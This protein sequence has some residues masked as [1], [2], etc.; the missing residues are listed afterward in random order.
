MAQSIASLENL[1]AL[2]LLSSHHKVEAMIPLA[3]IK[4]LSHLSVENDDF[5]DNNIISSVVLNSKS[6]LRS[7]VVKTNYYATSFLQGWEKVYADDSLGKEKHSLAVLKAFTLCG[8]T[9]DTTFIKSL[10]KAIDFMGLL[11]LTLGRFGVGERLFFQLLASLATSSQTSA[12]SIGLRNLCLDML[13]FSHSEALER[14]M[15][16]ETKCSFISAFDTLTTLEIKG[17]NQ[18]PDTIATNPGLSDTLLEAIL[19]H[20]NL[21]ILK[22]SY[23]GISVG[24]KIPYLS[25][26]TV[27]AIIDNLPQLQGLEFAPEEAEIVGTFR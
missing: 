7:L 26:K 24:R 9:F 25:A 20:K 2:R 19:K 3:K 18:Y 23:S 17:Y 8:T 4:N 21:R 1:Q 27:A 11:E 6:T 14:Q 5:D 13:D 12:T 16:F 10:E 15:I 22:I